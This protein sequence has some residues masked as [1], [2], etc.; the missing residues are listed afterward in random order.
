MYFTQQQYVAL[1][2]PAITPLE[3]HITNT[4]IRPFD[5]QTRRHHF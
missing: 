2:R 4:I 3:A 5:E 1:W